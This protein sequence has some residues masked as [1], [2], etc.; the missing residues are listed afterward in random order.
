M[1]PR[2]GVIWQRKEQRSITH[3]RN[4][5]EEEEEDFGL[6]LLSAIVTKYTSNR[7]AHGSKGKGKG[8]K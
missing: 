2:E 8:K 7:T 1:R 6:F 4:K 5:K 3:F